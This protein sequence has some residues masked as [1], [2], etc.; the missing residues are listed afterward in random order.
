MGS[1]VA[2]LCFECTSHDPVAGFDTVREDSGWGQV[3]GERHMD[4]KRAPF[5]KL[6]DAT[7]QK[8]RKRAAKSF[9]ESFKNRAQ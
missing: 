9:E 7:P 4:P 8:S 1:R 5:L 2:Q 3:W 6:S